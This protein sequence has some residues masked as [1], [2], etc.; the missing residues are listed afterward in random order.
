[1]VEGC[2]SGAGSVFVADKL[3]FLLEQLFLGLHVFRIL[4]DAVHRAHLDALRFL[5]PA[6]AFRTAFPVDDVDFVAFRNGFI[7]AFGFADAA[8]DT[9]FSKDAES[10]LHSKNA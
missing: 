1:M 3:L 5:V 8:V 10:E 6:D 4:G 9:R 2:R 7:G